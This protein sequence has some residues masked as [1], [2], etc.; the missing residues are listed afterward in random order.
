MS[1]QTSRRTQPLPE[2]VGRIGLK[3]GL[4][5][6]ALAALVGVGVVAHFVA[7]HHG[8]IVTGMR[9]PGQGGAAWG[10]QISMDMYFV[11]IS[12]AGITLS[13]MVRLMNIQVLRPLTRIAE[14]LTLVALMVS[15]LFVLSD[16]GRP[17]DGLLNL[18][19][20]ARPLSPFFGTFTLVV[21][22]TLFAS[23]VFM[24]LSGRADA[25]QALRRGPRFLRPWYWLWAS[26]YRDTRA[27]QDRHSRASF[28]VALCILP[29]LV[30]AQSTLGFIFGI[31]GGRPGWFSALQAPGFVVLAGCSGIGAL[32]V[33][34]ALLR[35]SLHLED[36]ITDGAFRLL[37]NVLWVLTLVY[38]YF[39]LVEEFTASYAAGEAQSG[40][41]HE[42]VFGQFAPMFWTTIACMLLPVLIGLTQFVTKRT[43][44]A[45]LVV[46]GLAINVA[47]VLR[48]L[49]IVVPSQTHGTL[50]PYDEPNAGYVP[51]LQEV[52]IVV[53]LSAL[54]ALIY[55]MFV[56]AFPIVP[57]DRVLKQE[58]SEG[59]STDR[60][61]LRVGAFAV[62]L[63]AGAALA[64]VG[65][66]LSARVGTVPYDDPL[67]PFSPV[68]FIT[69]LILIFFSPAVYEIFPREP[70]PGQDSAD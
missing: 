5:M 51:S 39:T 70:L 36:V 62:T 43:S 2:P 55:L 56:H 58:P 20:Y 41:A 21:S 68:I 40:L 42:V 24:Y 26:G 31:Q 50:L 66:L 35:R 28:W 4:A 46:A 6:G 11:G 44:V 8:L 7:E 57:S 38:L 16:L 65:L 3:A 54:G 47:A 64:A 29:L 30:I 9:N 67:L 34:A 1:G 17:M 33:V 25:Y 60:S 15:G 49:L 18:P 37:G 23:L 69:G 12:F 52:G 19:A 22:G 63:V 59:K 48:R 61:R 10:I 13:A 53:G 27:E 14:L 45:W 32:I